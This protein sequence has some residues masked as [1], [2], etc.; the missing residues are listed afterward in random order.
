MILAHAHPRECRLRALRRAHLLHNRPLGSHCPLA[1]LSLC[2]RQEPL[3]WP[4]STRCPCTK[5][6][7]GQERHTADKTRRTSDVPCHGMMACLD[8]RK[9]NRPPGC[10]QNVFPPSCPWEHYTDTIPR[11]VEQQVAALICS[12]Y[13]VCRTAHETRRACVA[14][15][16]SPESRLFGLFVHHSTTCQN[17]VHRDARPLAGAWHFDGHQSRRAPH[18]AA[19]YRRNCRSVPSPPYQAVP[20]LASRAPAGCCCW[21]PCGRT[22]GAPRSPVPTAS[23][24]LRRCSSS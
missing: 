20:S 9:D 13:T 10:W 22:R 5:Q 6:S 23:R 21:P 16:L 18:A 12:G 17:A 2:A 19:H 1:D 3:R 11:V 14:Q 4:Q 24:A 8:H 15:C 7:R